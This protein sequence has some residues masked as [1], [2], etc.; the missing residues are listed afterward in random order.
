MIAKFTMNLKILTLC[1]VAVLFA[2]S[3]VAYADRS[4][5]LTS[6]PHIYTTTLVYPGG[7]AATDATLFV[8]TIRRVHRITWKAYKPN[9]KGK[10]TFTSTVP[11]YD[12]SSSVEQP[13][14]SIVYVTS[15]TGVGFCF[16]DYGEDEGPETYLLPLTRMRVHVVDTRNKPVAHVLV[17][18][19]VLSAPAGVR[20]WTEETG[21]DYAMP[22]PWTKATDSN[23][24]A[25]LTHLPQ[26]YSATLAIASKRYR[27]NSDY[28][29]G[30]RL[31]YASSSPSVT[32]VVKRAGFIQGT[33]YFPGAKPAAGVLV[34]AVPWEESDDQP[35]NWEAATDSIGRFDIGG[36][37]PGTYHI[38]LA[39]TQAVDA[40]WAAVPCPVVVNDGRR[41]HRVALKLTRGALYTG[42]ITNLHT[43]LPV[44]DLRMEF[45]ST[46]LS[47]A[48]DEK[49]AVTD[50]DGRYSLRVAPGLLDIWLEGAPT[51]IPK[52]GKKILGREGDRR[53]LDYKVSDGE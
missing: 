24:W 35:N 27:I 51:T 42:R 33:A 23:G 38:A 5:Y 30:E 40:N 39:D 26:G 47:G 9:S 11:T 34:R 8:Y 7:R 29:P 46:T 28:G 19:E 53:R 20:T 52:I 4:G 12:W 50:S 48:K 45:T 2:S 22:S 15:P 36:L 44:E 31:Q 10:V 18:V 21:W 16:L 37:P 6:K 32:M 1:A 49:S 43:G 17:T 3:T 25:T 41:S 14:A 13:E